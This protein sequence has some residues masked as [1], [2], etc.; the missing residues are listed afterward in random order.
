MKDKI[1]SSPGRITVV[2]QSLAH[3]AHA[4]ILGVK[5]DQLRCGNYRLYRV[6]T[7]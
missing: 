7:A 6:A 4:V 1:R 2:E 3:K 5:S